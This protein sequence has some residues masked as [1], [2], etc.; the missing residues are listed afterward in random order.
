METQAISRL[1]LPKILTGFFAMLLTVSFLLNHSA[2]AAGTS[3]TSST[4]SESAAQK[5]DRANQYFEEGKNL[6][7]KSLYKEACKKYERAVEIDPGYAEAHSNLGYTYRKQQMFDKAVRAYKR[8]I[9]LDPKLA[10]AHEYLGEAYAEMGKFDL[11]QKELEILR[12]LGSD[13]AHE[14]EEFIEKMKKE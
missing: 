12:E 3:S 11:A 13:E 7:E 1:Y 2:Y 6:Q 10:E 5:R 9:K 14:L 8:A 4:K